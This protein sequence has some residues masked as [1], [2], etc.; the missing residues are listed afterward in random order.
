MEEQSPE[1]AAS[2]GPLLQTNQDGC[3]PHETL[4]PARALREKTRHFACSGHQREGKL[5][6][7]CTSLRINLFLL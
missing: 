4:D 3:S 5:V 7:W 2:R 6:G 1:P